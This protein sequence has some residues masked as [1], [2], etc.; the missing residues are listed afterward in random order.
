MKKLIPS[1]LSIFYYLSF[2]SPSFAQT[3]E[4]NAAAKAI[5][6][7]AEAT[8]LA[9]VGACPPAPFNI[10]C[11][12]GSSQTVI[13]A[14]VNLLF[15]VAIIIAVIFLIYGGIRW[16]MSKG[17]KEKVEESRNHVVAAIVGLIM[18]LLAYFIINLVISFFGLGGSISALKLPQL[19]PVAPK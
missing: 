11:G 9:N 14:T 18:I 2:A 10:L 1:A 5:Q 15:V 16:I 4:E 13:G 7:A 17:E 19:A 3:A 8:K 6:A 12:L